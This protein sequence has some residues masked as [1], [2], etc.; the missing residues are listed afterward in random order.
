MVL[1]ASGF[2]IKLNRHVLAHSVLPQSSFRA[3]RGCAGVGADSDSYPEPTQVQTC[4]LCGDG[5]SAGKRGTE[6]SANYSGAIAASAPAN[7]RGAVDRAAD[8]ST[9]VGPKPIIDVARS[10]YASCGAAG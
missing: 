10:Q 2:S 6:P 3:A 1:L 4:S 8:C 5:V 7:S 9:G